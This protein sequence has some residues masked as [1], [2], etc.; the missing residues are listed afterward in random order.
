MY[1]SVLLKPRLLEGFT[2]LGALCVVRMCAERYQLACEIR[3]P[4]DVY[5]GERKLAGILPKAKF[6]GNTIERAVLGVGL[7]VCQSLDSFAPELANKA[8]TLSHLHKK[9]LEIDHVVEDFLEIFQQEY[10][11]FERSG[12]GALVER[13]GP[14]L[15][16]RGLK[17]GA[18]SIDGK[19]RVLGVIQ[20]LGSR[21][22][23]C[24]ESGPCLENLGPN[25]RLAFL[26]L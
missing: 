3:W 16:G 11:L 6:L 23:L 19:V 22:E 25:E 12:C 18:K 20:G 2:L 14:F 24:F 8:T 9:R 21:G 1:L 26:P 15:Q 10:E 13:C 7:N 17:V 4:N 5:V